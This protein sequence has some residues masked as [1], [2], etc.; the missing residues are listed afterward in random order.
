MVFNE[1]PLKRAGPARTKAD[2]SVF[3]RPNEQVDWVFD[4]DRNLADLVTDFRPESQPAAFVPAPGAAARM[5]STLLRRLQA[6][7]RRRRPRMQGLIVVLALA[8]TAT[9]LAAVLVRV[10]WF[11]G[12]PPAN[13]PR[14]SRTGETIAPP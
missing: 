6:P 5:K 12:P 8:V 3:A 2:P 14:M 1:R 7:R 4:P 9:T 13:S 10:E 11:S